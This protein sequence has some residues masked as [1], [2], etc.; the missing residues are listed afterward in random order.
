[1]KAQPEFW[2]VVG[3]AL[4]L[5]YEELMGDVFQSEVRNSWTIM[6]NFLGYHMIEGLK[7]QYKEIDKMQ[8]RRMTA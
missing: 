2:P 3:E 7:F 5:V 8:S 4:F 6:Y 1:M